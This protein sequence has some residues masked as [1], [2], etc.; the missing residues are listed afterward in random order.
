MRG[1]RPFSRDTA[2]DV[3]EL[4]I[5]RFRAMSPAAKARMVES[6]TRD[7]EAL[8]LAGIRIRHP[9]AT[10][11]ELRLRLGGLRLG[12]ALMIEAYGWDPGEGRR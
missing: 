2:L 5:E 9:E 4:I 8:G 11:D 10:A 3:H 6:L 1:P 7:C 12:R